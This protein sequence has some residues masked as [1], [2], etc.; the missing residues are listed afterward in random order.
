M[1]EAFV[2]A[3]PMYDFPWTAEAQ[4]AIWRALA[5]RLRAAGIDAPAALERGR[6]LDDVWRDP[7][8]LFG[9][10]CGYPYVTSLGDR[11]ALLATPCY[12]FEGCQGPR[13]CSVLVARRGEAGKALTD[14]RGA[15][16]AVNGAHSNS[17]MNL[18]RAAIAPLAGGKPFFSS[19]VTTGSHAGS[20]EAIAAGR[21]DIAA[22]D[23]V[24]FA[25]LKRGRPTLTGAVA[26]V[27]RSA[28]SPG[29]PY[30]ASAH[31]P[32]EI[33]ETVRAALAATMADP[34]LSMARAALGLTETVALQ[35]SDYAAVAAFE[36]EAAALGYPNL[37]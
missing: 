20:L 22:I 26:V 34:S 2:A 17:G 33:V 32:S 14:F 13:H 29:L 21:A 11:I 16:A 5:A 31:L 15:R 9:Q 18:F 36:R 19:V 3:L 12:A 24:S 23:C 35:P 37:V 10:T 27:G 8:L 6:P 1:G 4:D 30:I 7:R 25:L 28:M